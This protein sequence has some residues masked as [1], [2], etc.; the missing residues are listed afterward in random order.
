MRIAMIGGI[1]L[2]A[3]GVLILAL[4]LEYPDATEVLDLGDL[5]A[6]VVEHKRVPDWLGVASV[7]AGVLV[8]SVAGLRSMHRTGR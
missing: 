3:L 5:K 8:I 6:R 2:V 7:A 4:G 1:L